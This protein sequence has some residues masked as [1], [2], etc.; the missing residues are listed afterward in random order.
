MTILKGTIRYGR[1]EIGYEAFFA[2]RKTMEIAVHPDGSV[3]VKAPLGTPKEAIEERLCK[4]ARWV[5]KQ[6]DFFRQFAPKTPP[7][8]YVSGETHLYLGRRYRLKVHQGEKE[9]VKLTRGILYVT[10][11]SADSPEKVKRLLS[12]WYRARAEEKFKESVTRCLANL[13]KLGYSEPELKIRHMK[14]RWGSLS[15]RGTLTLNPDLIKAPRD[16]IE[17]VITHELCHL[18]YKHHGPEFYQLLERVMPDWQKRKHKLE[19]ALI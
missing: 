19:L 18:K 10:L 14:T 16:C 11:V 6:L 13:R 3:V 8:Q 2:Q 1:Q 15:P 9:S 17:Y 12:D 5:I 7:R 4:R